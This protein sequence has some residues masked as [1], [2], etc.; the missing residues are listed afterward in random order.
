[1]SW[2]ESRA[3]VALFSSLCHLSRAG[4]YRLLTRRM[5]WYYSD[6]HYSSFALIIKEFAD[7]LRGMQL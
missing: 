1:M 3:A 7:S 6:D 2:S 4:E 5:C